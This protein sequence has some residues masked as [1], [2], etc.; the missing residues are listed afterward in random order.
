M[1]AQSVGVKGTAQTSSSSASRQERRLEIPACLERDL[2]TGHQ[3]FQRAFRKNRCSGKRTH[4]V[5]N[6]PLPAKSRTTNLGPFGEVIRATGPMAKLNPFRF[7]TKYQDDET[8][9]LYYGER[10]YNASTGRWLSRDPIEEK[11]GLNLY[12]FVYNSPLNK[13]DA[14]GLVDGNSTVE[15]I[16]TEANKLIA[17]ARGMG[18]T[19]G[20]DMLANYINGG[21]DQQLPV[22]WLRSFSKVTDAERKNQKRFENSLS[23]IAKTMRCGEKKTFSDNWDALISYGGRGFSTEELFFAS[24]DS[25]LSSYGDFS[26]QKICCDPKCYEVK[27]TGLVWNYWH[28]IYD[29]HSGLGVYILG[30]GSIPD[31]AMDKLRK[32]GHAK[33]FNMW[34]SWSQNLTGKVKSCGINEVSW[35]WS[36]P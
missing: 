7:S 29:F 27:I 25:T 31:S 2:P 17:D 32:Q 6:T 20:P 16:E 22:S 1:G 18:W 5:Q 36:Q 34:A 3:G 14:L 33:A 24:G 11:G 28:D 30:H 35:N 12:G 19:I 15:E 13:T 10:Y 9:L 21:G 4:L 8:D 23:K 26:L